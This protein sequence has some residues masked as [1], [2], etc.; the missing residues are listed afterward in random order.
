MMHTRYCFIS[1]I[2]LLTHIV[3]SCAHA[4]GNPPASGSAAPPIDILYG[5]Y[6][7]LG[8]KP[9]AAGENYRAW[10]RIAVEGDILILDRCFNGER[11]EGSGRLITVGADQMPAVRFEFPLHAQAFEATCLYHN[12]FDNLPRFS[13]Y[14]YPQSQADIE[15]PGLEAYFPIIWPVPMNYFDC[16]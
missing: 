8:K 9:G 6:E 2:L 10:V 3:T 15:V 4:D 11:L 5:A 16:Q 14:T 12:D 13:C 1:A 7:I